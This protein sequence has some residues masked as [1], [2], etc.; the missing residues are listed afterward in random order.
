MAEEGLQWLTSA[1]N[2]LRVAPVTPTEPD[3]RL[4]SWGAHWNALTV[5]DVWTTIEKTLLHINMLNLEA[6]NRVTLH[7]LQKLMGLTVLVA[8]VEHD[9]SAMGV[10]ALLMSWKALWAYAYPPPA[11]LPRV[12]EKAQQDQCELILI[13]THWSRRCGSHYS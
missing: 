8:S 1:H 13:A 9:L 3:T 12:L 4:F 7:W 5:S 10:D 11:L 6:I 2:V